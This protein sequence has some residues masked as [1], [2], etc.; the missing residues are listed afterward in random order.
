MLVLKYLSPLSKKQ[1]VCGGKPHIT[2]P[3]NK[4]NTCAE[5]VTTI[6]KRIQTFYG[7]EPY[8]TSTHITHQVHSSSSLWLPSPRFE[9]QTLASYIVTSWSMNPSNCCLPFGLYTS[10]TRHHAMYVHRGHTVKGTPCWNSNG[11]RVWVPIM[12]AQYGGGKNLICAKIWTQALMHVSPLHKL[13]AVS[14]VW[15][16]VGPTVINPL[17]PDDL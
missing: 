2:N 7:R 16:T 10:I 17:M 5:L 11:L 8:Q 6:N 1:A 9:L 4:M 12:T 13:T 3:I 14:F 15:R